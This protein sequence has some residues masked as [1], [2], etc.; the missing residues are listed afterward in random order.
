MRRWRQDDPFRVKV[1]CATYCNRYCVSRCELTVAPT[2]EVP[3]RREDDDEFHGGRGEISYTRTCCHCRAS[4][5]VFV[6]DSQLVSREDWI[7]PIGRSHADRIRERYANSEVFRAYWDRTET[8]RAFAA[9]TIRFRQDRE[10]TQADLAAEL[11][12]S[13]GLVRQL[14]SGEGR[15][16]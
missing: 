1:S 2:L 15:W 3:E 6:D 7:G 8:A 16:S 12:I 4:K 5:Q 10:L 9:E 13:I 14:E 11:G